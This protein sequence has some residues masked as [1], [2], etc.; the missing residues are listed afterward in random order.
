MLNDLIYRTV[1]ASTSGKWWRSVF[2]VSASKEKFD[3]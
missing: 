3:G 2:N 1:L